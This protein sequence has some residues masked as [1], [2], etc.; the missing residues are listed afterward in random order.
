MIL[1]VSMTKVVSRRSHL[2]AGQACYVLAIVP[3][4]LLCHLGRSQGARP[5]G[6]R[7]YCSTHGIHDAE[8]G[9]ARETPARVR[10][11]AEPLWMKGSR[12][13]ARQGDKGLSRRGMLNLNLI[14]SSLWH[15]N[16]LACP[17]R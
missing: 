13:G 4:R 14:L 9:L 16:P 5:K 12:L 15:P 10:R 6:L 2:M 11:T 7:G 8:R 17:C 3:S 1:K